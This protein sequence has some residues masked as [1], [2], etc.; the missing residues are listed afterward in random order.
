MSLWKNNY[1]V[2]FFFL[3]PSRFFLNGYS[4]GV[5]I[6]KIHWAFRKWVSLEFC[7]VANFIPLTPFPI[8][9]LLFF[10]LTIL[11]TINIKEVNI[12]LF[13]KDIFTFYHPP[14]L[15]C[16]VLTNIPVNLH[17]PEIYFWFERKKGLV[18]KRGQLSLTLWASSIFP[19]IACLCPILGHIYARTSYYAK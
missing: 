10:L 9:L 11:V 14:M 4:S 1:H 6:S 17:A 2:F 7:N 19:K 15:C 3:K 8:Y 5:F 12:S 16:P 13:F 18:A